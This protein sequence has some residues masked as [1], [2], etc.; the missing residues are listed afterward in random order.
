MEE[1]SLKESMKT[2]AVKTIQG[3]NM[4]MF[5]NEENTNWEKYRNKKFRTLNV[6]LGG[7]SH[8]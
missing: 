5:F 4:D 7:K 8:E 2:Q 1:I 6:N 3:L